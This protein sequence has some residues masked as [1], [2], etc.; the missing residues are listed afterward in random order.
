MTQLLRMRGG[1][2]RVKYNDFFSAVAEN[3]KI[4]FTV[5]TITLAA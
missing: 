4:F 5:V 2:E 1:V 3:R